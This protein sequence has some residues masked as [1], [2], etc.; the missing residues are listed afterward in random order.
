MVVFSDTKMS[1]RLKHT[2]PFYKPRFLI[3]LLLTLCLLNT[4]SASSYASFDYSTITQDQPS[5]LPVD[6]AFKFDNN[7]TQFGIQVRWEIADEYYLYQSKIEFKSL[8]NNA[9]IG[10]PEYSDLGIEEEDP[11]FGITRV[12]YN[13]LQVDLPLALKEG[14]SDSEI[15]VT[16]QGCAVAGLCYPPQKRTILWM[17]SEDNAANSSNS[18]VA[19][20]ET[21]NNAMLDL[22]KS[23]N[24]TNLNAG[25]ASSIFNFMSDSSLAA[26]IAIFFVLGLGLTFTPCVLPMVPIV[27]SIVA[28]PGGKDLGFAKSFSL[29]LSYVLG[30]AL[31]YASLGLA[32]G[33]LGAG[34]NLQA[35]MQS[36]PVLITF[37]IVFVALAL[38]MFGLYELQLPSFIRDKLEGESR[39]LSGGKLLSVF[40]I[41]ALSAILVS[42][43]VSAP[44]AGALLYISTSGDPLIG[45]ASLLSL[46]LGMGVPLI[47]VAVGGAKFL[48]KTGSWMN[49]S[50]FLFGVLLL[51]VAIWLI[52]RIIPE[53]VSLGL[54]AL[55]GLATAV[56]M[57]AFEPAISGAQKLVKTIAVAIFLVAGIWFVGAFTGAGDP[58]RPLEKL[59]NSA[60]GANSSVAEKINFKIVTGLDELEK[61]L[62]A[63]NAS[64]KK[65]FV[66]VYADWC[67]SC[68]MMERNVFPQ[69]EIRSLLDQFYLIKADVTDNTVGNLALLEQFKLFGPPSYLFFDRDGKELS[70]QRIVGEIS[71]S[72]FKDRLESALAAKQ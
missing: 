30:M 65:A 25:D 15:Q 14:Q 23:T 3:S 29:A 22:A 64:G 72:S 41:G 1:S 38:S 60:S 32:M 40:F 63:A 48:P 18:N 27:T 71:Q 2:R 35:A 42:P 67:I 62:I 66:D 4:F 56:F 13:T 52:A 20:S 28:G 70:Q 68:V 55:L 53:P 43:C 24:K 33:L 59:T 49:T 16:Y 44:L 19:S 31:T 17:P 61:E 12:V 45:F 10:A 57:G 11:Y 37:A 58:L 47:L 69:P 21:S 6:E 9:V 54:W 46:G 39:K 8:E 50:K 36:P 51:A 26:L 34:A 5:F 7:I